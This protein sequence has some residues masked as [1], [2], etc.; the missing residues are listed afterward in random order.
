MREILVQ[1][2]RQTICF[3]YLEVVIGV[4]ILEFYRLATIIVINP[5]AI[6]IYR[7]NWFRSPCY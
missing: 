5:L 3:S 6:K 2:E 7:F 4:D 1:D